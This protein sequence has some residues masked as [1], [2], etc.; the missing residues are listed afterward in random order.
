MSMDS[1]VRQV[2]P[3]YAYKMQSMGYCTLWLPA[4]RMCITPA[5]TLTTL[6][7]PTSM[8]TKEEYIFDTCYEA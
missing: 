6:A 7:I 4:R 5:P 3:C 8:Y 1:H 2:Q